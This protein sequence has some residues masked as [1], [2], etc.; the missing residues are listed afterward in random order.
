M[1]YN[2]VDGVLC[3]SSKWSLLGTI[4]FDN[5]SINVLKSILNGKFYAVQGLVRKKAFVCN[6][7]RM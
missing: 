2:R 3:V 1:E 4:A 5:I 6:Q 7:R